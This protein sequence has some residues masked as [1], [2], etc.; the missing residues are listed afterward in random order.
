MPQDL[1]AST[2]YAYLGK[3]ESD[4]G[5]VGPTEGFS[6]Q[7]GTIVSMMAFIRC[8]VLKSVKNMTTQDLDF[9]LDDRAN[10]VGAILLHLAA[11]ETYYSLNTFDGMAWDSWS[12]DIKKTWDIPMHLGERARQNIKGHSLD[13]Y[14][15][16]LHSVREKTLAEF[17]KRDD[18]WLAIVDKEWNWNNHA[19]WFHVT[20]HESNHN[21]QFKFLKRRL[22]GA[23]PADPPITG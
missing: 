3:A 8:R 15:T 13:Y 10:T 16:R 6:P 11:T 9:L 22:P 18:Q 17:R 23:N 2:A 4:V 14:L 7:I 21:G 12:D 20:E 5:I 1:A 19:K